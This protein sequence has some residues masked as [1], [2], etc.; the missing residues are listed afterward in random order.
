MDCSSSSPGAVRFVKYNPEIDNTDQTRTIPY[1][2]RPS[3]DDFRDAALKFDRLLD[4]DN[5]AVFS[6]C[7]PHETANEVKFQDGARRGALSYF[8]TDSL[9]ILRGEG[10]GSL[11][12][13]CTGIYEAASTPDTHVRRLCSPMIS[14]YRDRENGSSDLT[15]DAGQAHGAHMDDEYAIFPFH[16]DEGKMDSEKIHLHASTIARVSKV[17]CLTS[18]LQIKDGMPAI[19]GVLKPGTAGRARLLTSISTNKVPVY[20]Q[21]HDTR[22][23]SNMSEDSNSHR[24]LQLHWSSD[25]GTY[26]FH[27]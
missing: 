2:L 6:A 25:H 5:Y 13:H 14:V 27:R 9:A 12:G 18:R 8:L 11:I 23:L 17:D 22:I 4:P 1:F 10:P 26:Q 20:V 7:G 3:E 15:L 21:G 24:F 19:E 16:F